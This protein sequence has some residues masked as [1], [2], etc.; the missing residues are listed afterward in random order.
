[1]PDT[2]SIPGFNANLPVTITVSA[3]KYPQSFAAKIWRYNAD[4]TPDQQMGSA[5]NGTPPIVLG[6]AAADPTKLYMLYG[7]VL[8]QN[9]NPPTR[10]EIEAEVSQPG[11]QPVPLKVDGGAGSI[12]AKDQAFVARFKFG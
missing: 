10:Y 3:S 8:N 11:V 6:N 5:G 9:D 7:F 12:G 2:Q 4:Q 1:M